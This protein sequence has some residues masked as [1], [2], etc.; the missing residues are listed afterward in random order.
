VLIEK[1]KCVLIKGILI[2]G[3]LYFKTILTLVNVV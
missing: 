2:K 1:D 3:I